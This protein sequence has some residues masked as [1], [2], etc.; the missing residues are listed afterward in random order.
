MASGD[1]IPGQI[2]VRVQRGDGS[3]ETV[4]GPRNARE[5]RQTSLKEKLFLNMRLPL[6]A[7]HH[8]PPVEGGRFIGPA[9]RLRIMS[10]ETLQVEH[11][12]NTDNSRT[13]DVSADEFELGAVELD[14]NYPKGHNDHEEQRTLTV[15]DN[16][17]SSNP[18][19]DASG[20]VSLFKYTP[21]HPNLIM[22][23]GPQQANAVE[24]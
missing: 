10:G 18:S 13:I 9:Q 7:R 2:R 24:A 8:T 19:E 22:L 15:N 6:I 23:G 16:E 21:S 20:W 12:S 5:W 4:I 3:L 1:N 14:T 17:V 11:Q